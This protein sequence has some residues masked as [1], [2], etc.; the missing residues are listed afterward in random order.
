M[1]QAK[2]KFKKGDKLWSIPYQMIGT[3]RR[4]DD[5]C[6]KKYDDEYE[7]PGYLEYYITWTTG[8]W[9]RFYTFEID[10]GDYKDIIPYTKAVKILYGRKRKTV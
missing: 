10:N 3:I 6:S 8:A 7:N 1:Q 9:S 2:P 4:I 5:K